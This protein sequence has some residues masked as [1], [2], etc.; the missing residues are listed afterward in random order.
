MR[1]WEFWRMTPGEFGAVAH[2]YAVRSAREWHR[3]AFIV[4]GM[5]NA[6]RAKHAKAVQP[7]DLLGP[8]MRA[9]LQPRKATPV[10]DDA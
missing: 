4:A 1:P 5:V 3:A 7:E 2:G 9:L 6:W 8:S 10:K